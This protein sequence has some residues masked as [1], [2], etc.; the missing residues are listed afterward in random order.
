MLNWRHNFA[1]AAVAIGGLCLAACSAARAQRK[2]PALSGRDWQDATAAMHKIALDKGETE[3]HRAN[4]ITA[5]VKVL[6]RRKRH[7]EA[8]KLCREVL[9]AADKTAVIDAALRAGCLVERNRR[10]HLRA[11][12]NFL[13]SQSKGAHGRAASAIARELDRTVHALTSLAARAMV[14]RAVAVRP[15]HW[16][17]ARPGQAPAALHVTQPKMAPP[18]WYRRVSFPLL[19]EPKK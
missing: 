17:L 11:E 10:G 9:K 8:M 16:A 7:D 14:P 19:K 12:I 1:I 4:A 15:P 5:C 6:L 13:A 18:H 3:E 2:A